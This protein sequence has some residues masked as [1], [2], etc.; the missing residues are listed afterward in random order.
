[1]GQGDV[2]AF[3][4]KTVFGA[5][6][7]IACA[8]IAILFCISVGVLLVPAIGFAE[9][10]C[11]VSLDDTFNLVFFAV[12]VPAAAIITICQW[13]DSWRFGAPW[14]NERRHLV[15]G[16]AVIADGLWYLA[17]I[18][19]LIAG[20]VVAL[21]CGVSRVFGPYWLMIGGAVLVLA[22][23]IGFAVSRKKEVESEA[24]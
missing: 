13:I 4:K 24:D 15:D 5:V 11:G 18:F 16:Y 17:C 12:G 14:E 19:G 6:I 8:V 9:S 7:A 22:G 1:V 23:I 21:G 3:V 10:S 20:I 2:I